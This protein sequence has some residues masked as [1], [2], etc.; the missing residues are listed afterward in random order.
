MV[1]CD[2]CQAF[3]TGSF[4][5]SGGNRI[6]VDSGNYYV[7]PGLGQIVEGYLLIA[8]KQHYIGIGEIPVQLYG[9]LEIVLDKVRE[10]LRDFYCAPLFFEHG[11]ATASRR[12]GCCI[13]HAHIHAMPVNID[14]VDDIS[15]QFSPHK[16]SDLVELKRLYERGVPYLFLESTSGER[17]VFE[18]PGSIPSQYIRRIIAEKIGKPERW[19]WGAYWGLE[20]L[21][22]TLET[23]RGKII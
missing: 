21:Q 5:L 10:A 2:F 9:E 22:R 3:E 8:S 23:L 19:D 7:F 6:L 11:P 4:P 13:E 15:R 17:Y 12:G 16:I 20:E 1:V 18:I 14:I